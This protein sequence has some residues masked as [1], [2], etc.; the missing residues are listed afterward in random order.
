MINQDFLPILKKLKPLL[1]DQEEPESQGQP[2]PMLQPT[3]KA[4]IGVR[5]PFK[6]YGINILEL[7][8]RVKNFI[9]VIYPLKFLTSRKPQKIK[10]S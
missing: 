5:G 1:Q 10:W 6:I 9:G 4:L 8:K 7:Q 2:Q 3:E